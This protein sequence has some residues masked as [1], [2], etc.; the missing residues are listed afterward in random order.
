VVAVGARVDVAGLVVPAPPILVVPVLPLPPVPALPSLVVP[1]L[2]NR[3]VPGLLRLLVPGL[4]T[5][6]G[7]VRPAVRAVV[8]TLVSLSIFIMRKRKNNLVPVTVR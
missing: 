6:A 8:V 7:A 5:V 3:V 1:G 4:V 2:P